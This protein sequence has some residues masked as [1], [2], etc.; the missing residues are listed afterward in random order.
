MDGDAVTEDRGLLASQAQALLPADAV[1]AKVMMVFQDYVKHYQGLSFPLT[2][3][4]EQAGWGGG[5]WMT[6]KSQDQDHKK[7]KLLLSFESNFWGP[8]PLTMPAKGEDR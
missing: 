7:I 2:L 4:A 1:F 8:C 5:T 6:V 3:S